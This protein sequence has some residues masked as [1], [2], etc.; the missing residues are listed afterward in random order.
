LAGVTVNVFALVSPH[1][2]LTVG[3]VKVNVGSGVFVI[4][5]LQVV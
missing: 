5:K 1:G 3:G 2:K 4:V